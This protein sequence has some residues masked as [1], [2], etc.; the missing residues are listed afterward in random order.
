MNLC[1]L[2]SSCCAS[3]HLHGSDEAPF[4]LSCVS[5]S[6]NQSKRGC[7]K[8]RVGLLCAAHLIT[9]TYAA[10]M[11]TF[12]RTVLWSFFRAVVLNMQRGGAH[13]AMARCLYLHAGFLL[14][15]FSSYLHVYR[16]PCCPRGGLWSARGLTKPHN[17]TDLSLGC[18]AWKSLT[19]GLLGVQETH[20]IWFSKHRFLCSA[21]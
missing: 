12:C 16:S 21:H 5:L 4:S 18:V 14:G 2:P 19:W 13:V 17:T 9:A 6:F 10:S 20:W 1:M 8:R 15:F 11:A 3:L 7:I